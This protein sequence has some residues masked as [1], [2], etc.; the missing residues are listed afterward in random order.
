MNAFKSIL[1][2][3]LRVV[4]AF[5]AAAV[6]SHA[7]LAQETLFAYGPGGP[8]P[9]MKEA[10]SAFEKKM[11]IKVEVTAGPTP[12]WLDK[13]KNN[14]DI[15]F[16][17]SETMMTDFV[18][19]MNGQLS[20]QQVT[21]LY[22]RPLSILVRPGNP[23]HIRGVKDLF[24]PGVKVLVVNGAGQN[25]VWEDMAGRKGD[26]ETVAALRRNIVAYSKNSAE[27]KKTWTDN[28]D[29]DV[30]LIWNI[31]Q[32]AN[33]QLADTVPIERDYV[34]YRDTGV[35]ITQRAESKPA[36]KAFVSFL[37]SPQG[38]KIFGKWGWKTGQR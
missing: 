22:L 27:A 5:S 33:A 19:A 10:A 18:N 15:I 21:P 20:H 4:T 3:S 34:I 8:A 37:Q 9:A 25:G 24:K 36:A 11:G 13:A 30:W 6:L 28:Q 29:I 14:A 23:R 7:A 38:A 2:S 35:A 26:I 12:A 1:R 31:W 16:S 32:V 17:G